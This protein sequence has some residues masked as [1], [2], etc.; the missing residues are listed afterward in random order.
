MDQKNILASWSFKITKKQHT[1]KL[2]KLYLISQTHKLR[3]HF[4]GGDQLLIKQLDYMSIQAH[5]RHSKKHEVRNLP[6]VALS[7]EH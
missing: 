1:S 5:K 3:L 4:C 2:D 6:S 7:T